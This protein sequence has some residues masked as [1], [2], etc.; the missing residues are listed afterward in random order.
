LFRICFLACAFAV[1]GQSQQPPAGVNKI[2]HIVILIKENHAFDNV[3]GA[4]PGANGASSGTTSTGQVVPLYPAPDSYP[5]DIDHSWQASHLGTDNGKMDGFDLISG[6][7]E[8][9]REVDGYPGEFLAYRRYTQAQIPNY[10]A[11]A[12]NFVLADRM[13]SSLQGPSFPNHLYTVGAQSGGAIA[14]PN[15]AK[16]WGCDSATGTLVTTLNGQ[17]E[18]GSQYPCFDFKTLADE[19][20]TAGVSWKYYAPGQ[21]QS[22]YVWSILNAINHIRNSSY[23]TNNV[24]DYTQFITDAKNGT[25]PAVSWLITDFAHSEHPPASMCSGENTTVSEMNAVMQG[26]DWDSTAVFITWDD[27]GG[28]YDHVPPPSPDEYG[29]GIR[30][31]LIVVSPY[32][33]PS[34]IAHAQFEYSSILKFVE[35]RYGL[36]PLTQR[37]TVANDLT[38]VFDFTQNPLAPLVLSERTCPVLSAPFVLMGQSVVGQTG[39]I[40]GE[41]VVSNTTASPLAISDIAVL[42]ASGGQS[43]DF[44]Q[45]NDC[46]VGSG[47]LKRGDTCTVTLAFKPAGTGQRTGFLVVS[48]SGPGGTQATKLQGA[49][50]YVGLSPLNPR[51]ARINVGTSST[52]IPVTLTNSGPSAVSIASV[53]VGAGYSQTNNCGA[54][55][56]PG[57]SCSINL[58]FSPVKSGATPGVLAVNSSDPASPALANIIGF[59]TGITLTPARLNFGNQA[60]G[61]SSQP[62]TI[63]LKNVDSTAVTFGTITVPAG[64]TQTNNCATVQPQATCT[65][66]VVFAPTQAKTYSGDVSISDTDPSAPQTVP[67]QGT[68]I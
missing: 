50:A 42:G 36:P 56:P 29:L 10:Y 30:V 48:D 43:P 12:Q 65:I 24:V 17:G 21:D 62:R 51:F 26:P 64:F 15:A 38:S 68:G 27:F 67:V 5:H 49:G 47:T 31:P 66:Q 61:T 7:D 55:V 23:W 19:L 6:G 1:L 8:M 54:S 32:A 35:N 34:F 22:G 13:Y 11:Y 45:T 40:G 46:P 28:M 41:V 63:R 57:A 16:R 33:K 4:F 60:V 44:S 14:N 20:N 53:S 37:D 2:Q 3:F 9:S 58:T 52:P 25:L 18:F 59:G 39:S